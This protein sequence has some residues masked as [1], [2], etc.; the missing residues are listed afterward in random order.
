MME[1]GEVDMFE[2]GAEEDIDPE[3]WKELK[4]VAKT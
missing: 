4:A 2:G 1:G 3:V